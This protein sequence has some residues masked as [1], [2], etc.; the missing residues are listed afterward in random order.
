MTTV[1]DDNVHNVAIDGTFDDAQDIK[2]MFRD[3][4]ARE[5]SASRRSTPSTGPG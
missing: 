5:V 2:A 4:E 1:R 3:P